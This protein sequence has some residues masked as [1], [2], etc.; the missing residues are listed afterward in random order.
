M[1][2]KILTAVIV[3]MIS[4][5]STEGRANEAARFDISCEMSG[6]ERRLAELLVNHAEQSRSELACDERLMAFAHSRAMDMAKRGY[7]GHVTPERLGPNE[8]LRKTGYEMP[9][10]YVGGITNSVESILAGVGDP[11]E[12]WQLFLESPVHRS[13]LLGTNSMYA[14]QH[15]FGVARVHVPAS[16]FAYYWVVLIVENSESERPMICSP[17]PTFC[18]V[19]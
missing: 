2:R 1:T 15:R 5:A 10:Y 14:K 17:P 13:H 19:G 8:L 7:F 6:H 4:V 12:A 9:K 18:I 16:E 11:E 3:V